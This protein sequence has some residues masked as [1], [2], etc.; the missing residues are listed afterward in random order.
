MIVT[1]YDL[2]PGYHAEEGGYYYECSECVSKTPVPHGKAR[3]KIRALY[4]E[5][6]ERE[7]WDDGSAWISRDCTACGFSGKYI[8]EGYEYRVES[9]R[10]A[11]KAE[12]H[13]TVYC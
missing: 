7:S 6:L 10:K 12:K 4:Q 1:R 2:Y 11:G 13:P 8:G 5:A 3:K 9:K